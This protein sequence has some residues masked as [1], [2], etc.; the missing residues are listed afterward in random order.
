MRHTRTVLLGAWIL[1]LLNI[2]MA[3]GSIWIFMRM[4]PA[5]ERIIE[6]NERSLHACEEML[7]SLV[8]AGRRM[9]E[10]EDLRRGFTEAFERA[11]NNITESDEPSALEAISRAYP[12]AFQ[13]DPE[14]TEK[15]VLAITRLSAINRGAMIAADKRAR[16]FGSAGAWGIVFMATAMFTVG[17]IFIRSLKHNF[18]EP[19]EE[20]D[21]VF[22]AF[23]RG[24]LLRRCGSK[25]LSPEMK[26]IFGQINELLDENSVP[27]MDP[28]NDVPE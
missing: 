13:G 2:L 7:E 12:K 9:A 5:I 6:Q 25:H 4:A 27:C 20:M 28:E 22:Q 24:D 26:K 1:I 3:L 19:L 11:R 10:T 18:M 21:S 14:A 23:R 17:M 8:L 16:Q 15:T